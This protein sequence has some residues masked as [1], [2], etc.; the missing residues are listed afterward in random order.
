MQISS[1]TSS[2]GK[3]LSEFSADVL[4]RLFEAM[5]D[6]VVVFDDQ[7]RVA[8]CNSGMA[9]IAGRPIEALL[10]TR[11]TDWSGHTPWC[12]G[13]EAM[14]SS[15]GAI[16]R[17]DGRMRRVTVKGFL[18]PGDPPQRAAVYRDVTSR[19]RFA[20]VK[21]ADRER[22]SHVIENVSDGILVHRDGLIVYVNE[23]LAGMLGYERGE[24]LMRPLSVLHTD[25]ASLGLPA[26]GDP[27]TRFDSVCRRKDGTILDVEVSVST[28]LH[29]G[30]EAVFEVVRDVVERKRAEKR[31]GAF[32][33]LGQML[34]SASSPKEAARAV[35][36][37][38]DGLFG[39]DACTLDVLDENGELLIPILYVDTVDGLR[40][41]VPAARVALSATTVTRQVLA[42]GPRLLLR[43]SQEEAA[44][45]KISAFGSGRPS[46]S[47]MFVPIRSV[48]G[49]VGV[50]SLQSYSLNAYAA[51]DMEVLQALADYCGG[52]L[53]RTRAVA[54]LRESEARYREMFQGNS[55]IQLIVEPST[56]RILEANQAAAGFYGHSAAY[57]C[58]SVTMF[59]IAEMSEADLRASMKSALEQRQGSF[60]LRHRLAGGAL[61]D[62]EVHSSPVT[63][64]GRTLL[65][66]II[67]DVT[68]R[69]RAIERGRA[70]AELG[71]RL[72]A[73]TS[74][75][76][77]GRVVT[78]IAQRVIGWDACFIDLLASEMDNAAQPGT[79]LIPVV[80]YDT[81]DDE[82]REVRPTW[83]A[84]PLGSFSDLTI[85]EGPQLILRASG[86]PPSDSKGSYGN[87]DRR[88]ASLM[89]V[90]IHGS[91]GVLGVLSVQSYRF[92]AYGADDL[93]VLQ[94]LADHCS[95][96]LERTKAEEQLRLLES[97]VRLATDLVVISAADPAG[98][99]ATRIIFVNDAFIR[100]TGW[101]RS[102][103]IGRSSSVLHGPL[104]DSAEVEQLRAALHAGRSVAVEMV[105]YRKDGTPYDV[106]FSAFP[107]A[108]A[109]GA[110][111]Y[112][113][114]VQ[115]DVT[116]RRHAQRE[117]A[118]R[119]FHDPLT[120]LPNRS[121]FR[122]RLEHAMARRQRSSQDAFAVL[123]LD[124]D[125]FKEINDRFGHSAGDQVLVQTAR[126]LERCVRPGDT[127]ARL[128]GDEFIILLEG[129]DCLDHVLGVADRIL[130]GAREPVT[131][132]ETSFMCGTSIGICPPN[133][134]AA[135]AEETI[136][137]ADEA[138]Y[139]AKAEG[140]GRYQIAAAG[141]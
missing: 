133:L 7:D 17:P 62:V 27:P 104:T 82:I 22:A 61:R 74:P 119:A 21:E 42:E 123:Y 84:L 19:H 33:A 12:S 83:T 85:R 81:M 130:A 35:L 20:P 93:T 115:R 120:G 108:D 58:S 116:E 95:G 37:A 6:G 110:P 102:E 13:T 34:N 30:R 97:A 66:A 141:V 72:S 106:E 73:A 94:N 91:S 121:L 26:V 28:S 134:P 32:L 100:H 136:R 90:P 75:T 65:H 44:A 53:E 14:T 59:E 8:A 99:D 36:R 114:S 140:K 40:A 89:F 111:R 25:A 16:V 118:W 96:A 103:I 56:G 51:A 127:V 126:R 107:I 49:P 1:D 122:E 79:L 15:E 68:Q 11:P 112:F 39:Y 131:V 69:N 88:S 98:G 60:S 54:G 92:G 137:R 50:L 29:D 4:N 5:S 87:M 45:Q 128:G 57:L 113:V 3:R 101:A 2:P 109:D 9:L 31:A 43:R 10:G 18:I 41:E 46:L 24:L 135:D 48:G 64:Q 132:G 138:L 71:H 76:E 124:L 86:R 139:R 23:R 38:A 105:N 47:L 77:V 117:L 70:I 78:D 80:H 125:S 63:V 52:A 55:A 129:T 67:Q